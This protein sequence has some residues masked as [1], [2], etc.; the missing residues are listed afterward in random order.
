MKPNTKLTQ[1]G[2]TA[3][4]TP[5]TV[6]VPMHRASTVLFDNVADLHDAQSRWAKDE[7]IPTYATLNM[8]QAL[9]LENA[10]AEIEGGY[11]AATYPSGLAAVAGALLACVKSGDHVL[12]QLFIIR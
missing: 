10:V 8:P 7:Q 2:R 12:R 5:G 6:N 4:N 11:R 9:A 3:V 1:L